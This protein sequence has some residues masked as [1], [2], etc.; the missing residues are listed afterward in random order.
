M[1]LVAIYLFYLS[2]TLFA[3]DIPTPPA[4][5]GVI[6]AS[7]TER[8]AFS[9]TPGKV[10]P[11]KIETIYSWNKYECPVSDAEVTLATQPTRRI[12]L[13]SLLMY[14]IKDDPTLRLTYEYNYFGKW[15]EEALSHEVWS[16]V[17]ISFAKSQNAWTQVEGTLT[18]K[19]FEL[20]Y[21]WV[22]KADGYAIGD[23]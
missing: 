7:L 20:L 15:Q 5:T 4:L 3:F 19:K 22:A 12:P 18:A 10:G 14:E 17:I 16:P 11:C 6:V 2:S 1:K 9:F 13:K 23:H 8:I 21:H